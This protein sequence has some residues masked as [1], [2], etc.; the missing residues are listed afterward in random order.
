MDIQMPKMDGYQATKVLLKRGYRTPIVALTAHAMAEERERTKAVGF[1]GHLTKPLNFTE[2]LQTIV[3]H[4]V[5][6]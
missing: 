4:A 2:L 6:V 1:S 3:S 5:T